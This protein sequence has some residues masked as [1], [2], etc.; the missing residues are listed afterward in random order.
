MKVSIIIPT[1]NEAE[2]IGG[3]VGYL[4]AN[5]DG[6]L[7]EIIVCDGGSFDDTVSRARE[8]GATVLSSPKS[9][10]VQMNTGARDATGDIF[11][12]IHADTRPPAGFLR[13]IKNAQR[14]NYN[15]G[16]YKTKFDS[17]RAILKVN[18][19]FTRLDLFICMGGDQTLF[20]ERNIFEKCKGF[21]ENMLIMEDYDLTARARKIGNYKILNGTALVS[22]RKYSSNSWLKV[23]LANSKIVRMYQRGASQLEMSDLYKKM[24]R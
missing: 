20:I 2:N 13:D 21:N 22:A 3:L 11:Y 16:R 6:S 19:W 23:Q 5:N 8:A 7:A 15:L 1:Y 24:L 10:A 14:L 18:A 17:D 4:W 12:F 9:R